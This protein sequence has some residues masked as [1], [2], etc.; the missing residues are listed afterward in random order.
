MNHTT[1]VFFH[2]PSAAHL[3]ELSIREDPL[4]TGSAQEILIQEG[5]PLPSQDLLKALGAY[6]WRL[7]L[8]PS[9]L[10]SPLSLFAKRSLNAKMEVSPPPSHPAAPLSPA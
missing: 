4:E 7:S 9:F 8:P 10:P 6:R 5:L 2:C 3:T 1:R